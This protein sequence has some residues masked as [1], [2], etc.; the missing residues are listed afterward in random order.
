MS[1]GFRRAGE[2]NSIFDGNVPGAFLVPDCHSGEHLYLDLALIEISPK[3]K[4]IWDSLFGSTGTT[5]FDSKLA[6]SCNE[7][8]WPEC[9]LK[10]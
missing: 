4:M 10:C 3:E 8:S 9:L 5:R 6:D 2:W 1:G 7:S